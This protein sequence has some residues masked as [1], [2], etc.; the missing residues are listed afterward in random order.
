MTTS[1]LSQITTGT[2]TPA[3]DAIVGVRSGTT[4]L[5]LT[6]TYTGTGSTLVLASGPSITLANGTGLPLSTGV[7]G[8]LPVN[9]LNSGTAA[10]SSTFWRGDATWATP[11]GGGNVSTS[12][13][14]TTSS[15][16]EWASGTTIETG[17]LTGDVTTSNTMATTIAKIAGVTVGTPTG[18]TNV[19]FSSGPSITAATLAGIT[20]STGV[21]EEH[22]YSNGNSGTSAA[23]NLDNGNLQSITI[24]GAVTITQTTPTH[25]GKY[26]LIVTQD[27][28]GHVYS[29]SGVKFPG[30]TPPSYSSAANAVDVIS[31]IYNG[32][33]YYGMGGIAFA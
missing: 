14:P 23:I 6:P 11:S 21:I 19:V 15:L 31:I 4:D 5:L 10:S 24:T 2:F 25:P 3:T 16:V 28:T 22:I 33:N 18:N 30:G 17:N 20:L 9:N 12:G 29:L 27:G 8:N 7:T 13:S 32:T 1:K 26:T